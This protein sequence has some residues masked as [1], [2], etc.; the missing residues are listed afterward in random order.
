VV[1]WSDE[2][3]CFIATLPAWRNVRTHGR[4]LAQVTKSAHDVLTMLIADAQKRREKVPATQRHFSG[5]L[6]LRL[7]AS[8]HARLAR[9]AEREGI[10]LNQW[11]ITKLAG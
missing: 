3:R 8:L 7:P 2:D 10:S 11:I 4:T 9:E 6:N 5:K 1:Q